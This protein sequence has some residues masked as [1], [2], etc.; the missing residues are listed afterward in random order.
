MNEFQPDKPPIPSP[1]DIGD[2]AAHSAPQTRNYVVTA[3]IALAVAALQWVL[4]GLVG[5]WPVALLVLG[6][7]FV[8]AV[9]ATLLVGRTGKR[10][11][12]RVRRADLPAIRRAVDTNMKC[13]F[14]LMTAVW[15]FLLVALIRREAVWALPVMV[16]SIPFSVWCVSVEKKFKNMAAEED[17]ALEYGEL[18][19]AWKEM[20]FGLK[21]ERIDAST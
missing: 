1:F 7:Y 14:L 12:W 18:I 11:G 16:F 10:L 9:G 6:F 5:V 20:R 4:A 19:E 21:K 3:V 17:A 2:G 15:P 13:A 8:S